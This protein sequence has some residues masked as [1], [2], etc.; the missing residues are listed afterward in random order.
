[1]PANAAAA[2]ADMA[3]ARSA[4]VAPAPR[5]TV[6]EKTTMG[7]TKRLAIIG[8]AAVAIAVLTAGGLSLGTALSG[9]IRTVDDD[10]VVTVRRAVGLERGAPT[11]SVG[12]G[13]PRTRR[14]RGR[15]RDPADPQQ[16]SDGSG[17][18]ATGGTRSVLAPHRAA[19]PRPAAAPPRAAARR[20]AVAPPRAA[21]R[22][23]AVAPLGAGHQQR[24]RDVLRWRFGRWVHTAGDRRPSDPAE[25]PHVH[26]H[27]AEPRRRHQRPRRDRRRCP[28]HGR[29]ARGR[30]RRV[31]Q[32]V[33]RPV[34]VHRRR[35]SPA[36]PTRG[37]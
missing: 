24:W 4:R 35:T 14:G 32:P 34:C 8:G 11:A 10:T 5:T 18:A 37:R 3:A 30:G 31:A 22:R 7:R 20:P 2:A 17:G 16:R 21:A 19:V 1:M 23:P 29:W 33:T 9:R 36:C 13:C 25:R 28:R 12:A 27:T 6:V 15:R 26:L